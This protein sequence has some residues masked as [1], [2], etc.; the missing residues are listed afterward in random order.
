MQTSEIDKMAAIDGFINRGQSLVNRPTVQR[1][2]LDDPEGGFSTALPHT[3][4]SST[5]P[6]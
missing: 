3:D 6:M 2:L 1:K 5:S 4:D